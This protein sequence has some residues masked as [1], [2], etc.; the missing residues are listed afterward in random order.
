[1]LFLLVMQMLTASATLGPVEHL[2]SSCSLKMRLPSRT[3]VDIL[4]VSALLKSNYE[5]LKN[6]KF[7]HSTRFFL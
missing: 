3:G 1:M 6:N 5:F 4:S 7:Q 2:V